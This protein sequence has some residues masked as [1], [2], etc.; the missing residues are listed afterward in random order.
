MTDWA[1]L[2]EAK[3]RWAREGRLLTGRR[4]DPATDR[5][6][7]G[8]TLVRDWPVLDLGTQP[9]IPVRDWSFA[10]GGLVRRPL[11]W[12]FV[13]LSRQPQ[14]TPVSDLHCVTGWSR[15]DN[16]W[17]G[18]GGRHLLELVQPRPTARFIIV[19][20]FDAYTTVLPAA[21]LAKPGVLLA[22]H[23]EGEPLSRAHGGPVR[24]IVPH[25]YLWKSAKWLRQLWFT[26]TAVKGTWE[27]RGYHPHGDPWREERYGR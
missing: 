25:L 9:V 26:D 5:L 27:A 2:T 12:G 10:V 7:P 23:W 8:Q 14:S 15:Y 1:K 4:A 19:K 21:D 13:E 6:P 17:R 11:R 22:T 24:L 20:G 18:V 3:E 16:A